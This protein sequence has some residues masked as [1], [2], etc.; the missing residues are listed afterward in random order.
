M[1]EKHTNRWLALLRSSL[2]IAVAAALAL[3]LGWSLRGGSHPAQADATG[4]TDSAESDVKWWSCSMH[5]QVRLPRPGKCP[6]CPMDLIPV[7]ENSSE[8]APGHIQISEANRRRMRVETTPVERRAVEKTIRMVGKIDYDETRIETI[9][10]RV[11]G[12]IERLYVDFTG[13]EVSKGDH[14]VELFSPKLYTAQA[15]L[16]QARE[17][18]SIDAA[19]ERLAQLGLTQAQIASVEERRTPSDRMTVFAPQGGV[20]LHKNVRQGEY[21]AEGTQIVTIADLTKLWVMLDAYETDLAWLRYGQS[22]EFSVPAYPGATFAGTIAFI[23]TALDDR[24]RTVKVRVNVSNEDR[25][26][27]PNMFVRAIVR[28]T[29][30]A[31]GRVMDPS[32]AG[33]W[34]CPMHP[35]VVE[36]APGACP[37]CDMQLVTT[38]SRGY[39]NVAT[40]DIELPLAIPISA[41]LTTGKRA[42]VFV[43]VEG[44]ERPEYEGREVTL[45]MRAGDWYLVEHGLAEGERVVTHG[46]FKLDSA[47]Q[48]L[49]QPSM[50]SETH[51][52]SVEPD[53]LPASPEL[54]G[55]LNASWDAYLTLQSALADDALEPA[56]AALDTLQAAL[57]ELRGN[58]PE[59]AAGDVVLGALVRYDQGLA[60]ARSAAT[61]DELR[62]AFEGLNAATTELVGAFGVEHG[63]AYEI[64]CPMAL[65]DGANWLQATLEVRNPYYGAHMLDCGS[66]VQTLSEAHDD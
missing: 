27:K 13:L 4:A 39:V 42:I 41:A 28:P 34:I 49:A 64:H 22:V 16:L 56:R 8:L 35:D 51:D 63:A 58:V 50:M 36:E 5:A 21:I 30:A 23:D 59:G 61:L 24:T 3:W 10:A 43:E 60:A 52:A 31:G 17:D 46:N 18:V 25:R 15:E 65:D 9:T 54:R 33:R 47:L 44:A 6:L 40:D 7:Y 11:G 53:M 29:I 19:R 26:L 20:V 2:T 66:V 37:V 14:L 45:G 38:E 48:I 55:A 12:R 62:P 32:L 57:D 1:N